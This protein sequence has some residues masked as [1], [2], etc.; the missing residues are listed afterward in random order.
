MSLT[1]IIPI[2]SAVEVTPSDS[3]VFAPAFRAVYVG[4]SGDVAIVLAAG[5]D[6]VVHVGL[7]AGIWHPISGTKIMS[8]GT[9]A[10]DILVGF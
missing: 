8:T 3:T 7:A 6:P 2:Q 5:G 9:D 1:K 4:V 10:T